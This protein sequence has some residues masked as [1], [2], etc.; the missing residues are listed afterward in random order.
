MTG[1]KFMGSTHESNF[2][3]HS[4]NIRS[5][6]TRSTAATSS[7]IQKPPTAPDNGNRFYG[8]YVGTFAKQY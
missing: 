7:L 6:G 4:K 8:S 1:T 5:I 2:Y 3:K